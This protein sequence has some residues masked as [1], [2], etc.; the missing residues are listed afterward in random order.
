[1]ATRS[2]RKRNRNTDLSVLMPGNGAVRDLNYTAPEGD[3][4]DGKRKRSNNS[5]E[6]GCGHPFYAVFVEREEYAGRDEEGSMILINHLACEECEEGIGQEALYD[7]FV[8][9]TLLPVS[10]TP[11]LELDYETRKLITH[12]EER[13]VCSAACTVA[14]ISSESP[15]I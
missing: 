15:A 13:H 2:S 12:G 1:M 3:K 9:D 7:V 4:A 14:P 10:Q 8:L 11:V 5:K 6:R